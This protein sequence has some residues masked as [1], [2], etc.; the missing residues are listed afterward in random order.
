M[1]CGGFD[2]IER[3]LQTPERP[4]RHG[5]SRRATSPASQGRSRSRVLLCSLAKRGSW[6][7]EALTEGAFRRL[8]DPPSYG[9]AQ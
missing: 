7:G 5:A 9:V 8:H 3:A 4:L 6:Q 1:S 2:L